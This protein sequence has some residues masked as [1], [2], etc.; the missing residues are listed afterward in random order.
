VHLQALALTARRK[1]RLPTQQLPQDAAV[2]QHVQHTLLRSQATSQAMQP[3]NKRAQKHATQR[4]HLPHLQALALA[5]GR[6]Q[7]LATQQ[8]PK[9]AT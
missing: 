5:D 7:R 3:G 4:Y 8:L 9:D 2:P 6:K 1:Q